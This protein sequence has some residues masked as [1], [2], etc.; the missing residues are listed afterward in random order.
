[1]Y[2]IFFRNILPKYLN[3]KSKKLS[4]QVK[5]AII[6]LRRY[7]I[8]PWHILEKKKNSLVNSGTPKGQKDCRNELR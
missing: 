3:V 7:Q 1:M 8:N 2:S 6:R 4:L 5:Q